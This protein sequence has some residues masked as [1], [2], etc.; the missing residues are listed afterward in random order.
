VVDL[1]QVL[2]GTAYVGFILGAVFAVLELRGIGR[3]RRVRIVVDMHTSFISSDMTEVYSKIIT[4]D[5]KSAADMEQKC[6]H[7]SL[8]KIAGFFE[9]AGYITRQKFADPKVVIE[10]LPT[11]AVWRKMQPWVMFDR[12][13]TDPS[14]WMEFEYLA[15]FSE[16]FDTEYLANMKV[17][18]DVL[19]ERKKRK[20]A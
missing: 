15:M 14:Q 8:V 9:G 11:G 17:E 12:E 4:G 7:A 6:S 5:F 20:A 13:R 18:F 2:E 3:E 10:Y 19:K 16:H 1:I